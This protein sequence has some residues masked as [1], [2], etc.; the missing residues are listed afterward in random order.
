MKRTKTLT[1]PPACEKALADGVRNGL[2]MVEQRAAP[3]S[4]ALDYAVGICGVWISAGFFLDAWAHGH[5]P[6]ETFFTPY[7]AVF[8]TGILAVA[9][10]LAAYVL[11]NRGYGYA[12]ANA[13]PRAYRLA[14]LGIPI[15]LAGGIGD[16]IWHRL[17]GIEEG[18]DALLSP[19]H[20]ILGLGIFFLSSGPIRSVLSDRRAT[21][22]ARQLPLALGLA[23]WLI[24]VHFGTAYAFDPGAGRPNAPPSIAPFT[25]D[26]LTAL[27]IGYYK[28]ATGV[29]IVIFQSSLM[30]GFALWLVARTQASPGMLT[31][32]FTIGNAPA[33]AAFTNQ[34]PLLAVTLAQSLL[35]GI[36]ADVFVQRYDPQ[37]SAGTAAVFRRFAVG[38]PMTYI[39]VYLVAMS[40]AGGIWWDWNVALGAW[41]W[42]GVC[43]FALSLLILARRTE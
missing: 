12:W 42:S 7:H 20:Q 11:R 27:S 23:T 28:V 34:T 36:F 32:L 37:P 2:R 10:V 41:I 33:A 9:I 6:V 40:I 38:V 17:L 1:T 35:T 43:G 22:L 30:A 19:S 5:V 25:P 24:L 8:Y 26:Y 18:V 39:G 15:F 29:L 16:L 13:V 4:V 31:L 3:R 14:M 21:T